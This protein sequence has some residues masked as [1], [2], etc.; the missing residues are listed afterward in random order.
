MQPSIQ[1]VEKE[2]VM[3]KEINRSTVWF[4]CLA[5]ALMMTAGIAGAQEFKADVVRTVKGQVESGKLYVKGGKSW[6]DLAPPAM[7][8]GGSPTGNVVMITDKDAGMLLMLNLD[9]KSYTEVPMKGMADPDAVAKMVKQMGGTITEA[10]T[11]TVAGYA[12]KKVVY[13]Y[14]DERMGRTTLW[15]AVDLGGHALKTVVDNPYMSMTMEIKNIK[16]TP[17]SDS[18][19]EIPE[20]YQKGA[21]GFGVGQWK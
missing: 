13:A 5:V 17:V 1:T 11:E 3:N 2:R 16:K 21:G 14:P 9:E 7:G 20:G 4:L 8:M 18:K 19:F 12:C 6:S 10:G 15:Q